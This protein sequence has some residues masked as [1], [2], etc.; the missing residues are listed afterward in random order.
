[1]QRCPTSVWMAYAKSTAVAPT[2]RV[3]TRPLGVKTNTSSWS[4]SILRLAM[5]WLGSLVS[6]CQSTMR[7]SQARS[8]DE[9]WS[10]L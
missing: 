4:R 9:V 1:M 3:T 6:C 5:N 8:A 2:G 7:F 10:S